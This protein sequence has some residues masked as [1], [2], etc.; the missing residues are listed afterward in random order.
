MKVKNLI[1]ALSLIVCITGSTVVALAKNDV[2]KE[3]NEKV[4]VIV[5]VNTNMW[6]DKEGY[7]SS[8]K[9]V[10]A[11]IPANSVLY[12]Q[13]TTENVD[14]ALCKYKDESGNDIFGYISKDNIKLFYI[15]AN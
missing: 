10:I 8:D 5:T 12:V 9:E 6:K 7:Y 11:M 4:E 15:L 13:D 1:L 14:Y 3:D 2:D